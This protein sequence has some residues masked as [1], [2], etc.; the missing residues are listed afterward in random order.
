M[1]PGIVEAELLPRPRYAL[2]DR[3]S[4]DVLFVGPDGTTT[5]SMFLN[6]ARHLADALPD[7]SHVVNLCQDRYRFAVA[8]AACVLRK[9]VCLLT[10]D[11]SPAR[12][13]QLGDDFSNV[14]SVSEDPAVAGLSRH[15]RMTAC[16]GQVGPSEAVPMVAADQLA[17]IV[18]T[19]GTT[20]E[21]M[22]NRKL[23]GALVERSLA[24]AVRFELTARHRNTVVG[25]VPPQHM[26]G[27]E[28]TILLPL[29]ANVASWHGPAFY[30]H[31]I[32]RALRQVDAPRILVTTPL[33][34][35][36]LLAAGTECPP[37][38]KII[39]ATAP[40]P[41]AVAAAAEARWGAPVM[42]IFGATE[43]GSVASRRTVT[44]VAWTLYPGVGFL[45]E[46]QFSMERIMVTA[47]F[48]EPWPLND[49]IEMVDGGKF[50]LLGRTADMIKLAG[51]RASLAGLNQILNDIEG[52]TDGLF[53][54]PDDLDERSAARLLAYVVAPG[55]TSENILAALRLRMDP[56][57]LPRRVIRVDDLPRN[58]VGKL[59]RAALDRLQDAC[60]D[61]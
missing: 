25:T 16:L 32:R 44:D 26:Y 17:A 22:A 50:R 30:P 54:A 57:F 47:P 48:A 9:Q 36:N 52:V 55:Q 43:I 39:S 6:A 42:E 2:T 18:F 21:P 13:R 31:D 12:L 35:R 34:L 23:W 5:A 1:S 61:A 60:S 8:F 41:V 51:K 40:L 56:V 11:R 7:A 3:Q 58:E 15:H 4:S 20:G 59:P 49:N 10:S 14:I 19:S 29:H 28:T 37:S 27:F 53:V 38:L 46:R 45:P 33:H 24:A